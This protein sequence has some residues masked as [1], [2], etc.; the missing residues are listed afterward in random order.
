MSGEASARPPAVFTID[1]GLPFSD[2]LANGL[3]ARFGTGPDLARVTLLVPTRRAVRALRDAFLRE[4][5]GVPLLLPVIRPIGDV[6]EDDLAATEAVTLSAGDSNA[7]LT[8]LPPAVPGLTRQFRLARLIAAW[9]GATGQPEIGP[10][11][12][13]Q[14]AGELARFIDQIQTEQLDPAGLEALVPAEFA[15]HWQRTLAF[16][17]LVTAEWPG[18]LAADGMVDPAARRN[19]L[20][21]GLAAQWEAR[22]PA[23]PVIAAGSTGT[24][25]ASAALLRVVARL[26]QGAVVLPGLDRHLDD[27]SWG[28]LDQTHPQ[29]GMSHLLDRIGLARIEVASWPSTTSSRAPLSRMA[30]FSEVM[31]PAATSERWRDVVVEPTALGGVTRIT[32]PT[33]REEAGVI[34]LAMRSVLETPGKTVALVTPDRALAHRVAA[35][36]LRWGVVVDDSAGTPLAETLPGVFLRLTAAM[37]AQQ[38]APVALLAALKHPLAAGGQPTVAFR[39][40]ARRLELETLRGMR[41]APGFDGLRRAL[42]PDAD[43][44]QSLVDRLQ[45]MAMPF[46]DLTGRASLGS[47]I[48]AHIAF[49]EAFAATDSDAGTN[50]LWQG[51]AGETLATLLRSAIEGEVHLPP[52]SLAAYPPLLEALLRGQVVRPRYGTHPRASI[53][54]PLEARLQQADCLILGG[55]N[56]GGWPPDPQPDPWLSRPMRAAFGLPQPERRIGLAAHD[57]AQ[58]A[59]AAELILTRAEKVDGAPTVPSRWLLRLETLAGAPKDEEKAQAARLL[60]WSRQLDDMTERA[61]PLAPPAP[62]PPL[63][64][65]PGHLSVTEIETLIRNPY[66]IYARHV[67]GLRR[68]DDIDLSPGAA[69]RGSFLHKVLGEFVHAHPSTLPDDAVQRLF[70]IGRKH[71]LPFQDRPGVWA[72]WWP[73][74]ERMA[75]WFVA[76]E[77]EHR[78]VARPLAQEAPGE[79]ILPLATR[80]FRLRARADRIDD[81]GGSLAIIDYKSGQARSQKQ[82]DVGLAPQ[83]P[84][85]ALIAEAGGF[86]AHGVP[87]HPVAALQYWTLGGG[88]TG[89]SRKSITPP[90]VAETRTRLL[91]LLAYFERETSAYLAVPRPRLAPAY[92][93]YAHLARV[94]EWRVGGEE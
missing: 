59:G 29:F 4:T 49:A 69:D 12:A 65:R 43:D 83:L 91:E 2:A 88:R 68:L 77:R 5:D 53:W 38:Q 25:P 20:L 22:P 24:I 31:R 90:P 1:S 60:A 82:V 72:F 62:R 40:M 81:L 8:D 10:A 57:F 76:A 42:P 71:F 7:A 26:P 51:E 11:Q 28:L 27:E 32:C 21:Q 16:L 48:R 36:L 73:A 94:A 6:D 66:A 30:L 74:F 54:G 46:A 35:S 52:L 3:I 87:A 80:P 13:L 50:R 67:L 37:I 9:G 93:D 70:E 63:V 41:P 85:E 55:L 47:F 75:A 17:R 61:V 14:L 84:L 19:A 15:G 78:A 92:D 33:S 64:A 45:Q 58:A 39:A 79:L 44:L 18:L 89:G 34:A 56:E 86:A 23:D